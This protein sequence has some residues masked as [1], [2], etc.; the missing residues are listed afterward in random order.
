MVSVEMRE[1]AWR[2]ASGEVY[3]VRVVV[4][5][6]LNVQIYFQGVTTCHDEIVKFTCVTVGVT[7][8]VNS[9]Y[10]MRDRWHD[11]AQT[12]RHLAVLTDFVP[13]M[14]RLGTPYRGALLHLATSE[15]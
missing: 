1:D 4:A 6:T 9:S 5:K 12:V 3:I 14:A 13:K 10:N 15:I 11:M 2:C 8:F 7:H